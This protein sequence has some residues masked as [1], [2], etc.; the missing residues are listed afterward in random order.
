MLI[1]QSTIRGK[2]HGNTG[3][4]LGKVDVGTQEFV[5]TDNRVNEG[6][7]DRQTSRR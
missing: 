2:Y 5:G 4:L 7:R 3:Y 6:Q 1:R